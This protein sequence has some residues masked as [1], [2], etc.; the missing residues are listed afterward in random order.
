MLSLLMK[1]EKASLKS[2]LTF[3]T[4]LITPQHVLKLAS[5]EFNVLDEDARTKTLNGTL[6]A[7]VQPWAPPSSRSSSPRT[8][9]RQPAAS[10]RFARRS[11]RSERAGTRTCAIESK[12]VVHSRMPPFR[13][14]FQVFI[15]IASKKMLVS[16]DPGPP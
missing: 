10:R 8:A 4:V 16:L 5:F 7:G 14:A 11:N 15:R 6:G 2:E 12:V 1:E 13:S 3:I 9:E